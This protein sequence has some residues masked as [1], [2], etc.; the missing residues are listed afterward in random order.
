M[1]KMSK[2]YTNDEKIDRVNEVLDEVFKCVLIIINSI[3]FNF[4]KV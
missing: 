1:L 2:S 3:Y 4:F